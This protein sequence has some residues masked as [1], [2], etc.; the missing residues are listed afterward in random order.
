MARSK[1][2]EW[3]IGGEPKAA[4]VYV[5]IPDGSYMDVRVG[6]PIVRMIPTTLAAAVVDINKTWFDDPKAR[7]KDPAAIEVMSGGARVDRDFPA[8]YI[9][10]G[11]AV[12]AWWKAMNAA[13][14]ARAPDET[15][16]WVEPPELMKLQITIMDMRD[17]THRV[18]NDRYVVRS[19]HVVVKAKPEEVAA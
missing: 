10:E 4:A 17:R 6:D 19:R 9:N 13:G 3:P 2:Q 8:L 7:S 1:Q 18:G 11:L 15:F 5:K 16:V 12:L 14:S